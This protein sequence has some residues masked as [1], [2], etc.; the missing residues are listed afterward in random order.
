M[1]LPAARKDDLCTGHDCF[2]PRPAASGSENVYVNNRKS[3]RKG[4]TWKKHCCV[5][6]CH[7][8]ETAEGSATVFI[9]GKRAARVQDPVACG[10][11]IM[12]GSTNV[13]IGG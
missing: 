2:P 11:V 8:S 3:H 7:A 10:S 5:L 12:T 13:Y 6:S 9:N 1:G 4:D